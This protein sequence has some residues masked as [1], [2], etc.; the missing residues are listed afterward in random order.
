MDGA[1]LRRFKEKQRRNVE[2]EFEA[3]RER[4][5]RLS[6]TVRVHADI[7][8]SRRSRRGQKKRS[9]AVLGGTRARLAVRPKTE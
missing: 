9:D 6:G 4:V 1:A 8:S 7:R 5:A 3:M 2:A